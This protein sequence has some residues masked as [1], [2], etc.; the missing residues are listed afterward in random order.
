MKRNILIIIIAIIVTV[1]S[2]FSLRASADALAVVIGVILG[3]VASVPTTLLITYI[4]TRSHQNQGGTQQTG[5]S[6]QPPVVVINTQDNPTVAGSATLPTLT[7]P[8]QNRKWTVIGDVETE[9]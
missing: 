8:A 1:T 5:L 7:A 2:I 3:V 6:G 4:L 9:G